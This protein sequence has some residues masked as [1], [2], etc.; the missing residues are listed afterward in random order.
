VAALLAAELER[1]GGSVRTNAPVESIVLSGGVARGVRLADG[2]ERFAKSVIVNADPF[3]LQALVG[4]EH[5]PAE[6]NLKLARLAR[7]GTTLKVNLALS[8]FPRF[9]CL[10][11]PP[12]RFGPTIRLLPDEANVMRSL[13]EGFEAAMSGRLAEF[14]T[15]EWYVH[16][17][18]DPTMTDEQGRLS[19][20]LFVQWVP[21]ELADS[22]W[23]A[24]GDR[25]VRHLLSLCDRFAPGTSELVVDYQVLHPR[26][27]EEH[28]GITGGHIH[29]VDNTFG[30][31][32]RMPHATPIERL[33]SA[34]AGTH[35]A[36]S[37]IGCAG[38]LAARRC[39]REL[40]G[41]R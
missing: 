15:I 11:E 22:T 2:R 39:L 23:E 5:L 9:T 6:Y 37:V 31:A 1:H 28:F 29:H 10:P 32:D 20:A 34:S 30:F 38:Y 16:T 40:E 12:P 14:P 19:S 18:I 4:A 21:Y 26:A 8:A 33:Y 27:I 3:R 7:P 25:Y 36:G 41:A 35:P 17:P 24:E 13:R